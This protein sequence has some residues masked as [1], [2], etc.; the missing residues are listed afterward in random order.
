MKRKSYPKD[1]KLGAINQAKAEKI[2][3]KVS[4]QGYY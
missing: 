1:L 2:I 4:R 3:T